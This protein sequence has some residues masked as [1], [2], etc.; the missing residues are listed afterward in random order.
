MPYFGL[1]ENRYLAF[2][3]GRTCP[4]AVRS[5]WSNAGA[6]V[7]PRVSVRHPFF[8]RDALLADPRDVAG[9]DFTGRVSRRLFRALRGWV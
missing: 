1:P 2:G 7:R 5:G 6:R 4:F 9:D 3:L 8:R